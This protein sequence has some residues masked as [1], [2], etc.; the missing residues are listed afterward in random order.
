MSKKKARRKQEESKKKLTWWGAEEKK[1]KQE[2]RDEALRIHN[3][4]LDRA[5]RKKRK[6]E[7]KERKKIKKQNRPKSLNIH[8]PCWNPCSVEILP[9]PK[10]GSLHASLICHWSLWRLWWNPPKSKS[11]KVPSPPLPS[12]AAPDKTK[13]ED[14]CSSKQ[15]WVSMHGMNCMKCMLHVAWLLTT[16]TLTN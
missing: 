14:D 3:Y 1:K 4:N 5:Q 11:T 7:L 15:R 16:N 6:P 9:K 10:K 12:T 13:D 2:E 8:V